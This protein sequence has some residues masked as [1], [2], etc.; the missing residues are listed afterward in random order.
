M[1]KMLCTKGNKVVIIMTVVHFIILPTLFIL[2]LF[3]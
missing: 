1:E 3:N 2:S